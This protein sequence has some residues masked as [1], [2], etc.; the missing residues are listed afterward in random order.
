MCLRGRGRASSSGFGFRRTGRRDRRISLDEEELQ[1]AGPDAEKR[2]RR[3]LP[4]RGATGLQQVDDREAVEVGDVVEDD[5][6]ALG[7][8]KNG[9]FWKEEK[10]VK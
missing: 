5:D 3:D 10:R 9:G 4:L 6:G 7:W 8:L 1:R 2:Q